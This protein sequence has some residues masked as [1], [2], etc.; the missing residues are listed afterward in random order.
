MNKIVCRTRMRAVGVPHGRNYGSRFHVSRVFPICTADAKYGQSV[1]RSCFKIVRVRHVNLLHCISVLDVS[2]QLIQVL[3]FLG[4]TKKDFC[5][6]EII[7]LAL[8]RCF[9]GAFARRFA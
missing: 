8:S 7:F 4:H 2:F 3:R 1:K 6:S 9:G 5:G